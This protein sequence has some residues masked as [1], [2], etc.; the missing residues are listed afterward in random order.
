MGPSLKS[1]FQFIPDPRAMTDQRNDLIQLYLGELM[2][3]LELLTTAQRRGYLQEQ[4]EITGRQLY[5]TEDF[6]HIPPTPPQQLLG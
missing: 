3:L 6:L 5:T 4:G 2:S 1:L